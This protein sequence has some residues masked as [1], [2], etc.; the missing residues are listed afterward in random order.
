MRDIVTYGPSKYDIVAVHEAT[1]IEQ[2][3][4]AEGRYGELRVYY[5]PA[6]VLSDHPFCTMQAEWV[7]PEKTAAAELFIDY[8]LSSPAQEQA[9]AL[10]FRPAD[11]SLA[12]DQLDSPFVRYAA[13]GIM[14]QLPPQV[15]VPPGEVLDTLMRIWCTAVGLNKCDPGSL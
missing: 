7:T 13:N 10:G 9:L 2:A 11:P 3:A 6:T 1:A 5:P 8:L 15:D 4:N 12:L 14:T